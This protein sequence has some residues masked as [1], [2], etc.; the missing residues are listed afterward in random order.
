LNGCKLRD[1]RESARQLPLRS[2]WRCR[3]GLRIAPPRPSLGESGFTLMELM[4][5]STLFLILIGIAVPQYKSLT[6]QLRASSVAAQLAGDISFARVMS[7]RTATPY[8][9]SITPATGVSYKVQRSAAP[10]ALVPATDPAVRTIALS[11]TMPGVLFSLNGL[12][13]DPYGAGVAQATPTTTLSFSSRG[14][15]SISGTFF[16]S[17]NDTRNTYAVTVTGAGRVRIWRRIGS[18]WR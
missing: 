12:T 11:T 5:V 6:L 10:P 18:T 2:P 4:V 14:L 9:I 7:L 3:F 1:S 17:S 13:A 8:Y 15:P 16:V